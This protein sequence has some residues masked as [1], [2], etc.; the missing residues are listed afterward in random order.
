MTDYEKTLVLRL[1]I[2]IHTE[3]YTHL[4]ILHCLAAESV[5]KW[6]SGVIHS[7]QRLVVSQ[8]LPH[9][10]F[11]IMATRPLQ[12]RLNCC[13]GSEGVRG[14]LLPTFRALMSLTLGG[15][16]HRSAGTVN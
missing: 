16:H 13:A 3:Q 15:K 11:E 12:R 9:V 2:C 5:F 10:R 7:A 8:S 6:H 1:Q 4:K 14:P